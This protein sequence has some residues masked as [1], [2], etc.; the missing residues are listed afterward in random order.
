MDEPF[1]IT[2][3]EN[4][5]QEM[6]EES[7]VE[8]EPEETCFDLKEMQGAHCDALKTMSEQEDDLARAVHSYV[9]GEMEKPLIISDMD[10]LEK[11]KLFTG[12]RNKATQ[13][14]LSTNLR[15]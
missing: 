9:Y 12:I 11:R 2:D 15:K 8:L 1:T 6:D 3:D 7:T 14:M 13:E 5:Q 4:E 10:Y